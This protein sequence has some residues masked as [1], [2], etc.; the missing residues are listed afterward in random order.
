[1]ADWKA[2]RFFRTFSR[3]SQSVKPRLRTCSPELRVLAPPERVL[4]PW[5][6][7]GSFLSGASSRICTPPT[8]RSDQGAAIFGRGANWVAGFTGRR[9]ARGGFA[10]VGVLLGSLDADSG[11]GR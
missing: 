11:A 2:L 6:S 8:R 4:K 9:R 5:T 1:M 3:V 10:A 7:H